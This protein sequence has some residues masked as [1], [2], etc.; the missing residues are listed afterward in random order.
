MARQR[1]DIEGGRITNASD[2]VERSDYVTLGQLRKGSHWKRSGPVVGDYVV[3]L[4][5]P[6]DS[7]VIGGDESSDGMKLSV[8]GAIGPGPVGGDGAYDLGSETARWASGYFAATV[9]AGGL[10]LGA[11]ADAAAGA[12]RW[13]GTHFQGYN[14]AA[15][16]DLDFTGAGSS[17]TASNV[18]AG[19]IGV[20][21]QKAGGNFEYRG[22]NAGSSKLSVALDAPNNEID[23]DVVEANLTHNNIG[24]ILGLAKGGAAADLSAT[25]PG[26][27][28]QA[29]GGAVVTVAALADGDIP[30]SIVRTSRTIGVFYPLQGGGDLNANRN[31][32]I[33]QAS[34]GD[35]GYLAAAD[36][37]TFNAKVGPSRAI[38]TTA[39]ITGGGNLSADRTLAIAKATAAVDG[40]LA[41]VDFSTFN[42]KV[43]PSRNVNTTAPITG[44]GD[45][46]SD[47]TIAISDFV[48]SGAGHARGAVP[49]PGA[50]AG[51]AKFLR[52]D[53]TWANPPG[54]TPAALSKVDDTNVTL[55]L[56]G[57]PGS[58]LL[59]A[60]SIT[61]GW[62]GQLAVTRGGTG[63]ATVAQGDLV[64]ASAADTIAALAKDTNATRY[65]SNTGASNAPA[66]AQI[67]LA[68]GVT[69]NLPVGNLGSGTGASATTYWRGDGSWASVHWTRSGTDVSLTVSGDRVLHQGGGQVRMVDAANVSH[70]MTTVLEEGHYAAML[71]IGGGAGGLGIY[72][73]SDSDAIAITL[74]GYIGTATPSA[75]TPAIALWTAKK[76][77]TGSQALG[78][79]DRMVAFQNNGVNV[80]TLRADSVTEWKTSGVGHGI[81][82]LTETDTYGL[83]APVSATAG[84]YEMYGLSDTD[85]LALRLRAVIGTATPTSTTPAAIIDGSKKNGTGVQALAATDTLLQLR[86]ND[87]VRVTWLGAG[88]MGLGMVPT[89][90][91]D[92]DD[93][94]GGN[95]GMRLGASVA[96]STTFR[97]DGYA[98]GANARNFSLRNRY[99][100][101][102]RL[103]L[104]RSTSA[105]TDPLTPMVSWDGATGYMGVNVVPIYQLDESGAVR[106]AVAAADAKT[107]D[108]TTYPRP[109]GHDAAS[110]QY[111]SVFINPTSV[112]YANA[113]PGG[114]DHHF[115]VA[116]QTQV[117]TG[118]TASA[119]SDTTVLF[120]GNKIPDNNYGSGHTMASVLQ[121]DAWGGTLGTHIGQLYISAAG[122]GYTNGTQ[123]LTV[124]G[125]GT[126][127]T[128]SCTVS[129]GLVTAILSILT[130][131]TGY[132]PGVEY[133]L[134]GAGGSGAKVVVAPFV[135]T[136]YEIDI[137]NNRS[138]DSIYLTNAYDPP[139]PRS[140]G[141][142]ITN[143][144]TKESYAGLY[145][146]TVTAKWVNGVHVTSGSTQSTPAGA[147]IDSLPNSTTIVDSN[148][149]SVGMIGAL[150]TNTTRGASRL[151][152]GYTD[153]STITIESSISGQV[154]GDVYTITGYSGSYD[155]IA[156]KAGHPD[157]GTRACF[158]GIQR[159]NHAS[160]G[161]LFLQRATDTSPVGYLIHGVTASLGSLF[162]VGA[163]GKTGHGT[164]SPRNILQVAQGAG[165]TLA[166]LQAAASY[167]HFHGSA[168][169]TAGADYQPGLAFTS[170]DNN[171]GIPKVALIPRY[172]STGSWLHIGTSS[173]YASGI[174]NN[175]IVVDP[176]GQVGIAGATVPAA[177]L[178][179]S[180]GI[181]PGAV[182]DK[183]G[184]Y[185][186]T[187]SDFM[188]RVT[189]ATTITLLGA[190]AALK[191]LV[192]II[193]NTGTDIVTVQR[194]GSDTI[195][196]ATSVRLGVNKTGIFVVGNT[197]AWHMVSGTGEYRSLIELASDVASTASV[198]FQNI[199]GLSFAVKS[200]INYRWQA[201]LLYTTSAATI[202]LRVAVTTPTFT[203]NAYWTMTPV[204]ETGSLATTGWFNGASAQD[205][206]TAS[207][208]S[209]T[210]TG[211]NILIMH[212]II[213]P[214]ADGTVQLRFAPETA[215]ANGVIIEA[216][217]T[218][219]WW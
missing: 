15:W 142:N 148:A 104:M 177:A 203:H 149:F 79:T 105:G 77:G 83:H 115:A 95:L 155:Y 173:A 171:P 147:T 50:G 24:G 179:S 8:E 159:I 172:T 98:D 106:I 34:A 71:N 206:G 143:S 184:A 38:N 197:N 80:L 26:F 21:K 65:L 27:L 52:E 13:D 75:T 57:A 119:F 183:T 219:E 7:V 49:D 108:G 144:G 151:I 9:F 176:A 162:W 181:I 165:T 30:A 35:D 67:N 60:A 36:Y 158:G 78:T 41:A 40:Y 198:S 46:S 3:Q 96:G 209:M 207:S 189:N 134:T 43:G 188:L 55:T 214:S 123:T 5:D 86:N 122:S 23:L 29:S 163:D 126:D 72:G 124:D 33:L 136:G 81:T 199:T 192:Q 130:A 56:G 141:L 140:I 205:T 208:A 117:P 74:R 153:A 1:Q 154:A 64:Y 187:A 195:D 94:T 113:T 47:R 45:L 73:L 180:A 91:F 145:V 204:G 87:A 137:I 42:A 186:T 161:G 20:F 166:N 107:A 175:A 63:L 191:G 125:P 210:T 2:G 132:I 70:G 31:I 160:V 131:G 89:Y 150:F 200:G 168:N 59:A 100:A 88:H 211:G 121:I 12:M 170:E 22:L 120:L 4:V 92:L 218:L 19:G 111:Y 39:P 93:P 10:L 32:S 128:L 28:K 164:S 193:R 48:A 133:S 51:T 194:G 37:V 201:T 25:G 174:N 6:S 66:W 196:G 138:H 129:G 76:N 202:G 103:E 213:R 101:V 212:G 110:T 62:A 167:H 118:G 18:N 178:H 99:T 146:H 182:V 116:M 157:A 152:T 216:G 44:G 84:G 69:G 185:T 14:G 58:A 139:K 54:T 127:G 82:T 135:H 169:Y 217:S 90:R 215:T 97:M 109:I 17:D 68:N 53:A 190:T 156:F 61:A 85:A 102:G 16:V 11:A 114:G 112:N